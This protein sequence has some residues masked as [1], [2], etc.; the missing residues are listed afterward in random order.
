MIEIELLGDP[1][2]CSLSV[3]QARR[4]P[5]FF[6]SLNGCLLKPIF[7][8]A[9]P[10]QNF[11]GIDGAVFPKNS[12]DNNVKLLRDFGGLLW[13]LGLFLVKENRRGYTGLTYP[14]YRVLARGI[15]LVIVGWKEFE[16]T[17]KCYPKATNQKQKRNSETV[18]QIQGNLPKQQKDAMY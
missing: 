13:I 11:N 12:L 7:P 15:R 14:G 8:L 5:P 10:P 17:G 3:Y 1:D 2:I 18:V 4:K 9:I 6:Y 16:T